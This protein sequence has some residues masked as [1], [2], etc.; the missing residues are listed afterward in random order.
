MPDLVGNPEDR[1]SQNE[2]HLFLFLGIIEIR[3]DGGGSWDMIVSLL[4]RV[5][6]CQYM[7]IV[8]L[9]YILPKT[10]NWPLFKLR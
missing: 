7:Y 5:T 2:D 8:L 10:S 9:L 1:F 4:H 6:D 3:V